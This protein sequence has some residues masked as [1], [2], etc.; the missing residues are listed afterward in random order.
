VPE[1]NFNSNSNGSGNGNVDGSSKGI[2]TPNGA[3]VSP[4]RS[5]PQSTGHIRLPD[6]LDRPHLSPHRSLSDALRAVRSREEQETLL[7]DDEVADPDGCLCVN[8]G[9]K[10]YVETS[11]DF[12]P[13]S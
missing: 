4:K 2:T 7:G 8:P 10:L 11:T 9:Y 13:R 3:D 12:V 6:H 1:L 5:P